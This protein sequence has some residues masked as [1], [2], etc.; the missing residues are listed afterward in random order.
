MLSISVTPRFFGRLFMAVLGIEP[1]EATTDLGKPH[2]R[3]RHQHPR[4]RAA[5][6]PYYFY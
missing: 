6:I 4:Q 5:I 3:L 1:G 2:I